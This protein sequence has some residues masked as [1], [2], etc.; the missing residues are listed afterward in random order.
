[1]TSITEAYQMTQSADFNLKPP[2][3]WS[4]I[5]EW[6]DATGFDA[7]AYQ[8]ADGRVVMVMQAADPVEVNADGLRRWSSLQHN[9]DRLPRIAGR[10][11]PAAVE[12]TRT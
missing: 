7:R 2:D 1:M 4:L 5:K 11:R 8:A 10:F 9:A 6:H 3:G 12:C